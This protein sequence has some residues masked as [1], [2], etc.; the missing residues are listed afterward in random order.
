[1]WQNSLGYFGLRENPFKTNPDPRFLFLT[2]RTQASL[3]GL[4]GAIQARRGLM[5]L[6]GEVG[7]GKT[8]LI[9]WLLDW[10]DVRR[11]PRAFIFNSHLQVNELFDL[12]LAEFGVPP[13]D[14]RT[15]LSPLT[16]LNQWLIERYAM[17][18]NAVLI[19]DEAQG[20]PPHVLEEIRMLLNLET[21]HE[22]LLQIVLAGQPELDEKLKRP[23]LHQI[24][25][26]I[27]L[28]CKTV[29]LDAREARDYINER[30]RIG[31][32]SSA[33]IFTP[34]AIDAIHFYSGGIPRL[35]NLLCEYTLITAYSEQTRPAAA[36]IVERVAR[37]LQFEDFK[38]SRGAFKNIGEAL[39]A[40]PI[41]AQ[42]S[43]GRPTVQP[44]GFPSILTKPYEPSATIRRHEAALFRQSGGDELVE[45]LGI[46]DHR[47]ASDTNQQS[48]QQAPGLIARISEG[49]HQFISRF[50]TIPNASIKV[51]HAAGKRRVDIS[52]VSR[53]SGRNSFVEKL[54]LPWLVSGITRRIGRSADWHQ[55]LFS[56]GPINRWSPMWRT[57]SWSVSRSLA[58]ERIE[59]LHRWLRRPMRV[60]RLRRPANPN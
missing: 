19:V 17:G 26:R 1:M 22:R 50:E 6:T 32:A 25:Q 52:S 23:E 3:D 49:I 57:R 31:G 53:P 58:R 20:L 30:M 41:D 33:P 36:H 5:L 4:T 56:T 48:T 11:M 59:S 44:V 12:A 24:R 51:V 15:K 9:H 14:S 40:D 16:R 13:S 34:E 29:A 37:E 8:M 54:G 47:S 10:L 42:L 43:E 28:R 7:T 60:P 27:A 39:P 35:M 45:A 2:R 21:P 46:A 18:T 38:L 55:K